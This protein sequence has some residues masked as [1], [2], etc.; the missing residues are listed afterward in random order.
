VGGAELIRVDV[1]IIAAT[2]RDLEAAVQTGRFR[3]DLYYRIKVVPVH[4]P[5]LRDRKED[6]PELVHHFIYR[7]AQ[8]SKRGMSSISDEAMT[9]LAN[10]DWP[11]NVR[12]LANI[13]ERAVV[14]GQPPIIQQADLPLEILAT[15]SRQA[16]ST[17]LSYQEA[18]DRYHRELI[19]KTLQQTN[20]NRSAAAKILGLERSYFLK[21]SCSDPRFAGKCCVPACDR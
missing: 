20:G 11:G 8:E 10:Y 21:L 18:T 3:E 15:R 16:G 12:E 6:I 13:I 7:F 1:R 2:N 19:M 14:I 4:L 5:S 9:R 17:N